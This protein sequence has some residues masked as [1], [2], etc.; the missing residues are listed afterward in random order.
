MLCCLEIKAFNS[1]CHS[2]QIV[3]FFYREA[4]HRILV[5]LL[6]CDISM[7]VYI[8]LLDRLGFA[9][10]GIINYTELFA[11]FREM[12]DDYPSWMDPVQRQ[13]QEKAVMSSGQVHAQL[14]E[15]AK[16]R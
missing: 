5:V 12:P 4:M 6:G 2:C 7:P 1:I 8:R 9:E 15:K 11:Y 16:Q 14:R 10:K 13:W 3:C